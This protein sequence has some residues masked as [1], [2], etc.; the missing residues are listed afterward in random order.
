[1][2]PDSELIQELP[3]TLPADFGEWDDGKPP[4]SLPA[5]FN[6]FDQISGRETGERQ[7]GA[8]GEDK[9]QRAVSVEG[10]ATPGDG[11]SEGPVGPQLV[12]AEKAKEE[13]AIEEPL[14]LFS[15]IGARRRWWW[16]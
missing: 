11:S 6:E 16:R 7:A 5:D 15:A 1:M 12:G 2:A 13:R 10:K 8:A 4:V 9:A 3:G 14:K